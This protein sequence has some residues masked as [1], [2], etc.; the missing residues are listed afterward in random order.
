M[1]RTW[2]SLQGGRGF[3][4]NDE[5][6]QSGSRVRESKRTPFAAKAVMMAHKQEVRV[7]GEA[8]LIALAAG[9]PAT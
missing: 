5:V 1:A 6:R 9:G 3:Q 4:D 2:H 8:E 7:I